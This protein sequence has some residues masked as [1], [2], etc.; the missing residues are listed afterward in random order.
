MN[1]MMGPGNKTKKKENA[2]KKWNPRVQNKKQ[3]KQ[4][5][6]YEIPA[7]SGTK[8]SMKIRSPLILGKCS[9]Q[10][11]IDSFFSMCSPYYAKIFP[12]FHVCAT[13]TF[14]LQQRFT[15]TFFRRGCVF[16]GRNT[17]LS[18][19]LCSSSPSG[20]VSHIAGWQLA[21]QITW[22]RNQKYI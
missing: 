11:T 16:V 2:K 8:E 20:M 9:C 7:I 4:K 14:A 12:C 10:K 15:G 6:T 19:S 13:G 5:N 18:R 21:Q 1:N 22:V 17:S 3:K